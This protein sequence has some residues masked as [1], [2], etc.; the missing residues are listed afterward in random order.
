[1]ASPIDFASAVGSA[2]GP[3]C[4]PEFCN[5]VA[6][7]I[8]GSAKLSD[9]RMAGIYPMK[10]TVEQNEVHGRAVRNSVNMP[11]IQIAF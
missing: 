9:P 7:A 4:R 5:T 11:P 2:G 1:M 3:G 10:P 6:K 8:R